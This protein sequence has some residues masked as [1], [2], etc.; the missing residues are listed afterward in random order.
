MNLP[1]WLLKL[2][3]GYK[4]C[5][6]HGMDTRVLSRLPECPICENWVDS[7]DMTCYTIFWRDIPDSSVWLFKDLNSIRIVTDMPKNR[8][9][10]YSIYEVKPSVEVNWVTHSD[11][12]NCWYSDVVYGLVFGEQGCGTYL[13]FVIKEVN[14]I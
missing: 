1:N 14:G 12:P 5:E 9:R 4:P 13:A 2:P 6:I 10:N 7:K 3:K 8:G 11:A